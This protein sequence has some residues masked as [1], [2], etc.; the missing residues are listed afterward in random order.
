[1]VTDRGSAV[2]RPR[3]PGGGLWPAIA[4]GCLAAGLAIW[5]LASAIDGGGTRERGFPGPPAS[6]G[7]RSAP[8]PDPLQGIPGRGLAL[9]ITEPNPALVWSPTARASVPAPFD[10]WRRALGETRPAVYR[11]MVSW[12]HLQPQPG[13]PVVLDAPQSGC[14]RARGPCAPWAGVREQLAALASRQR[15]GGWEGMV[16]LL[17][18]PEW[19][20]APA[21]ACETPGS[22]PR[23]RAPRPDTLVHYQAVIRSLLAA[24]AEEGATLRYWSAWNE[25]NH[26]YFLARQ[27]GD[28]D[29]SQGGRGAP[30]VEAYSALVRALDSVLAA[31]PG[32]RRVIGELAASRRDGRN[33]SVS[34]FIRALPRDLV[35]AS[36]VF[37]QHGYAG[38]WDPVP[39]VERAL[40]GH[41]CPA[42]HRI[43]ITE[44]GAGLPSASLSE[45][46]GSV[47]RPRA[48]RELHARL[49]KW[50][51]APRVDVAVQY[52]WREDDLF[53]VGLV[54][55]DLTET[56]PTLGAWQA[57]SRRPSAAAPPPRRDCPDGD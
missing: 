28:C 53:R 49:R 43:W 45:G 29:G 42:R 15:E 11:L 13:G 39:D 27:R 41:A 31:A 34:T 44:T 8:A 47:T 36:P 25:P 9:G 38:G 10:R 20:A 6:A 50:W 56:L 18:T 33:T 4:L 24:A 12:R 37:A 57:W 35:C 48:C 26:A 21:D 54:S 7:T 30:S 1:V 40:A 16:V 22:E 2:R 32:T 3:V 46:A 5:Q 23:A 51:E 17:D 14:L 55:T 52:T 19:A